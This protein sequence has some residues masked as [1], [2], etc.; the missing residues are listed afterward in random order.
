LSQHQE[1]GADLRVMSNGPYQIKMSSLNNGKLKNSQNIETISYALRINGSNVAL[2]N[3]AGNPVTIGSG[4]A[5]SAAGD[6][7]NLKIKI[8]E[9]TTQKSAGLYQDVLTITAIAN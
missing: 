7:Y 2:F 3:S 5:T 9:N 4:T 8:L 6:R 1:K